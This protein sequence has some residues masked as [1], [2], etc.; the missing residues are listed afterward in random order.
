MQRN[1]L[2]IGILGLGVN[3]EFHYPKYFAMI[4]S[5]P[6]PKRA[7]TKGFFS[8]A[9]A[10]NPKPQSV[11]IVAADAE[12]PQRVPHGARQR[13]GPRP[14]DRL[15]PHLSAEQHRLR[16][17]RAANSTNPDILAICSIGM[18]TALNEI[19]FKLR[20]SARMVGRAAG[21]GVQGQLGPLLNGFV[22]YDFWLLRPWTFPAS[23]T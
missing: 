11:A 2:F 13:Q 12:S 20:S 14:Q 4:P 5:G 8:I 19:G 16:S 7:F 15:R 1:K 22:N 23:T 21:D 9:M 3:S 6:D 10:Q 17:H 18:V